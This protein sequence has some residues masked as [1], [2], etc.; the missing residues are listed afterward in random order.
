MKKS[1]L[2]GGV[3]KTT[4]FLNDGLGPVLDPKATVQSQTTGTS[5]EIAQKQIDANQGPMVG[6]TPQ[7]EIDYGAMSQED[8][9]TAVS[10]L[11]VVGEVI[12][13]KNTLVDLYKGDYTGAALNAA[14]F[15]I[16]FVP[17]AVLKKGAKEVAAWAKKNGGDIIDKLKGGGKMDDLVK[18][19]NPGGMD[20]VLEN[21]KMEFI[22]TASDKDIVSSKLF[23]Q[24]EKAEILGSRY[25]TNAGGVSDTDFKGVTSYTDAKSVPVVLDNMKRIG[26]DLDKMNFKASDLSGESVKFH[27]VKHGRAVVEVKLPN[28]ESQL[29]YKSSGLANKPGSG[30]G[31]TTEG[32][33]QPYGGHANTSQSDNW[34]IKDKGYEDFYGSESFRDISGNLDRIAAEEGYDITKQA[35]KSNVNATGGVS[36]SN[37]AFSANQKNVFS[38]TSADS[39][40]KNT[41]RNEAGNS[42]TAIYENAD[43]VEDVVISAVDDNNYVAF[44]KGDGPDGEWTS[45]MEVSIP[46][47]FKQ[48]L[49]DAAKRLP[50]GA[51][52]TEKTSIS[53]DGI[54]VWSKFDGKG[55]KPTGKTKKVYLAKLNA[56][57]DHDKVLFTTK[58]AANK[59]IAELKKVNPN[60]EYT[61]G[62]GPPPPPGGDRKLFINLELPTLEKVGTSNTN[63]TGGVTR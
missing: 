28:G 1:N 63:A 4:P 18:T 62:N 48:M 42:S 37:Y 31:G 46:G 35:S 49:L 7:Y 5:A 3:G 54:S 56:K 23:T 9:E 39:K 16:P 11:P 17:G 51:V 36:G 30:V 34:F 15:L 52:L 57:G 10:F 13:A 60:I 41:Y 24:D 6:N 33:W 55:W 29:F 22:N 45:K 44:S 26:Q 58:E 59:K 14:G 32:M 19:Y 50:E 40:L 61:I 38:S 21:Q 2:I 25:K 53:A 12:E 47:K 8:F 27:G 43:G 20:E